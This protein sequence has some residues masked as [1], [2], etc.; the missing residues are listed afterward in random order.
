MRTIFLACCLWMS[1]SAV[2]AQDIWFGEPAPPTQ[3]PLL[4]SPN[5]RQVILVTPARYIW[6]PWHVGPSG[7]WERVAIRYQ[8]ASRQLV[9]LCDQPFH[10]SR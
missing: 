3:P 6:G 8:P 9:W 1:G 4:V 10:C 2:S 5:C 7:Y